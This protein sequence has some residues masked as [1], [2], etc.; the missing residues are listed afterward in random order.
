MKLFQ[1][2]LRNF[3][4]IGISRNQRPFNAR[5]LIAFACYLLANISAIVFLIYKA[6][7]FNEYTLSI[8][9]IFV[10]ITIAFIYGVFVI[11]MKKIFQLID[12]CERIVEKSK[13]AKNKFVKTMKF[14]TKFM[15]LGSRYPKPM[16]IYVETNKRTEKWSMIAHAL[17]TIM[18]PLC[19][20]PPKFWYSIWLYCMTFGL[21]NDVFDLPIPMW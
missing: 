18:L 2:S 20:I 1:A 8:F 14:F 10:S 9:T 5:T 4:I 7:A 17:I 3:A 13:Q 6:N 19:V 12:F 16:K 21:D 11:E 15:I